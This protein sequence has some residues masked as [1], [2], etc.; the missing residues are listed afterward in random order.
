M[1]KLSHVDSMIMKCIWGSERDLR[2]FEIG[3][4]M[5]E[6]FGV[7]YADNALAT[8]MTVLMKKGFVSRYKKRHS[9]QYVAEISKEEYLKKL[10]TDLVNEWYDGSYKELIASCA[11]DVKANADEYAEVVKIFQ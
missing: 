11:E 2:V 4:L 7:S 3:E 6:K 10:R 9:Y 5:E 1:K 8:F